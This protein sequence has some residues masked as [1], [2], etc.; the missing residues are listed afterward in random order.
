MRVIKRYPNRKL[1]DTTL[2]QYVALDQV[3]EL[4]RKGEKVYVIDNVTG[5]DLTG[6]TL[7]QI[8][9]E[10]EK[11]QSG[12]LPQG[13]LTGLIQAGGD[14]LTSLLRSLASPLGVF[15]QVDDEIEQRIQTL[16][17]RGELAEEEG[18]RLLEKLLSRGRAA[19]SDGRSERALEHAL[20]HIGVPQR[21][22]VEQLMDQLEAL[23]IKIDQLAEE[24]KD[25]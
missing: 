16:I 15:R 25:E 10:Q 4:V 23:A 7:T 21:D 1:Y 6:L 3:A 13:V 22:E 18:R 12:T 5:E 19:V 9:F 11:K 24:R 14:T 2:K 20:G 8:I 17:A